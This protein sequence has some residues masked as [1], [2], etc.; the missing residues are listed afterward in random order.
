MG[1]LFYIY[2]M[3]IFNSICQNPWCKGQYSYTENDFVKTE[4]GLEP[5]K[6]CKK[7]KN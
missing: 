2:Y 4:D 1:F 3:E 7:C 6:Q 5:P